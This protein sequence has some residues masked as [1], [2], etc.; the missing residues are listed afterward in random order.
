[1]HYDQSE[2]AT[3]GISEVETMTEQVLVKRKP[4]VRRSNG[5]KAYPYVAC[6]TPPHIVEAV[7]AEA[8]RR[9]TSYSDVA[10]EALEAFV[11][12]LANGREEDRAA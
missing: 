12:A 3:E 11:C 10:R 9:G 4:R 1:M 8:A 6:R 7:K 2:H 5:S